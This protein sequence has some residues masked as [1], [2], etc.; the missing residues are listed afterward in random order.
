MSKNMNQMAH[1]EYQFFLIM[2]FIKFSNYYFI[3]YIKSMSV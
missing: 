3:K 2:I 1:S